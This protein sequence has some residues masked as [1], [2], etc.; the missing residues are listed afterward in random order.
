ME[1]C[2]FADDHREDLDE[3]YECG[4]VGTQS[5]PSDADD[6]LPSFPDPV[7]LTAAKVRMS[8]HDG[9]DDV[10]DCDCAEEKA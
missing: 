4:P 8:A 10:A 1:G 3:D 7:Y 5:P 2:E 6:G 9:A